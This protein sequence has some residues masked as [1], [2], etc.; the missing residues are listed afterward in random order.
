MIDVAKFLQELGLG[1]WSHDIMEE[2]IEFLD[3]KEG[4]DPTIE[5]YI[6]DEEGDRCVY[7]NH[8]HFSPDGIVYCPYCRDSE[9]VFEKESIYLPPGEEKIFFCSNCKRDF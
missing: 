6:Q 3:R 7:T 9:Y 8:P 4:D 5:V 1:Q 2:T